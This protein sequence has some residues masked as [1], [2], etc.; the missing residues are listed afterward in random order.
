MEKMKFLLTVQDKRSIDI[1][2]VSPHCTQ[3]TAHL[4]GFVMTKFILL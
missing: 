4:I 3:V 1:K 2:Y